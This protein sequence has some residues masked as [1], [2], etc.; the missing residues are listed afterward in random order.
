VKRRLF[1]L[2]AALL[3]VL[4]ILTI[5]MWLR[6]YLFPNV[7]G[8]NIT[9]IRVDS[10]WGC[11][12]FS[13][14]TPPPKIR[15]EFETP[16]IGGHRPPG[17]GISPARPPNFRETVGMIITLDAPQLKNG[18][19][20]HHGWYPINTTRFIPRAKPN[21]TNTTTFWDF[22][23]IPYWSMFLAEILLPLR[24]IWAVRRQQFARKSG[25]CLRC[26]YDLRA[27]P[28]RCP[29]CGRA[30]TNANVGSI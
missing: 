13:R 3:L 27:T 18:F 12:F 30:V 20:F 2:L 9:G 4:C 10:W 7:S 23:V 11:I 16:T 17:H 21:T 29:E 26:G 22:R 5:T 1:T 19:G 25:H 14:V 15:F 28:D 24:W 6:S 8:V